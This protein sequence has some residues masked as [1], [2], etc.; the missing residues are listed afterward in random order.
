MQ[1]YN[2]GFVGG[3]NMA[4]SLIGGLISTGRAAVSIRVAEPDPQ[5]RRFFTESFGVTAVEDNCEVAAGS[6]VIVLAVKPQLM[7]Q[8]LLPLQKPLLQ[9]N[10][11]LLSIAAGVREPDINHWAGGGR[12]IVRAMPN[13]P[14]LVGSGATGLFANPAVSGEQLEQAESLMR[15]VGVTVWL[16]QESLLDQVTALSGSGPAYFMLFM[17]TLERAGIEHGLDPDV[18]HLL[19][20]ETCLGTAKLAME[21]DEDLAELRRRVTSPGGTTESALQIMENAHIQRI[22]YDAFEAAMRRASTLGDQLGETGSG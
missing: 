22:I 19:V 15:A 8:V 4:R 1:D 11:L 18:A 17:E 13:T 21:S 2:I 7:K 10:P 6:D 3:G 14:A 16:R 5:K 12:A 20:M 9:H